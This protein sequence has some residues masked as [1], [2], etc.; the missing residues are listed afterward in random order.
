MKLGLWIFLFF[1]GDVEEGD[2]G[3]SSYMHSEL[4]AED[5]DDMDDGVDW[6]VM[7]GFG[8]TLVVMG[9]LV[10]L[11]RIRFS[12]L[13]DIGVMSGVSKYLSSFNL[14]SHGFAAIHRSN[15]LLLSTLR[16]DIGFENLEFGLPLTLDCCKQET[17][18]C[19]L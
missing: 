19:K 18:T 8:E 17:T 1:S 4:M 7:G 6:L 13:V 10:A 11:G 5:D 12:F 2:R 15:K 9:F 3:L 14:L 16:G